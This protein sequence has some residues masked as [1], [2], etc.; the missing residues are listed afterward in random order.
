MTVVGVSTC[1]RGVLFEAVTGV[2]TG[3]GIVTS[4]RIGRVRPTIPT[5]RRL[6]Y[7]AERGRYNRQDPDNRTRALDPR[8]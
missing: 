4:M 3:G 7:R 8:A 1:T 6:A 5:R 2:G